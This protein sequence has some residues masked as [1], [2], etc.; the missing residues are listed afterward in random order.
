MKKYYYIDYLRFFATI[1][2]IVWHCISNVYYQFGQLKE[3]LP[4]SISFGP[5]VRWSVPV[6]IMISGALLL[7][8]DEDPVIF[9]KKRFSRICIPV[10]VW[11]LLYGIVKLY[12]FTIYEPPRPSF[13]KYVII[14]NFA[15]FFTNKLSYHF[16]FISLI[17]GLYILSPFI[18]KMVRQLTRS[19][20]ELFLLIGII[21]QSTRVFFPNIFLADNFQ[22]GGQLIYFVLGYYLLTYPVEGKGRLAIYF[23]GAIS[24]VATPLLT[25]YR[26]YLN[27]VHQD[28]FY[29]TTGLFVYLISMAVFVL[30]QQTIADQ[31]EGRPENPVRKFILFVSANSFGFFLAHPLIINILLY[32][33]F[34]LYSLTTSSLIIKWG[35]KEKVFDMNNATGAWLLALLV[36]LILCVV[37]RIIGKLKLTKYFT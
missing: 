33:N 31:T 19:Q 9:Y 37:F 15:L 26:E 24:A 8:K 16:Y 18:S 10:I 34:R 28:I 7:G 6:F 13:F 2:V 30:F 17:L 27:S 35:G 36:F 21:A 5:L 12:H 25:Y 1:A 14:D 29:N 23:L 4:A 11:V 3:W 20:L 22:L 32:S